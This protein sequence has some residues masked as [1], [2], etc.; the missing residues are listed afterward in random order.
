MFN[1]IPECALVLALF[2][3]ANGAVGQEPAQPVE[4]RHMNDIRGVYVGEKQPNEEPVLSSIARTRAGRKST[5][6]T[7]DG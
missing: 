4:V 1:K 3:A 5:S 6:S 2:S 7:E